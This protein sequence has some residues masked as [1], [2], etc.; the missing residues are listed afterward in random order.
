MVLNT[1]VINGVTSATW[2]TGDIDGPSLTWGDRGPN[3]A[4]W[5]QPIVGIVIPGSPG[6]SSGGYFMLLTLMQPTSGSPATPDT[7]SS[8]TWAKDTV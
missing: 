4:E 5:T 3:R 1:V 6:G 2:G 7:I 8:A